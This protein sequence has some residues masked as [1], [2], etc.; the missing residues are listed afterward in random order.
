MLDDINGRF[1][2]LWRLYNIFRLLTNRII[3]LYAYNFD[4]SS[5]GY[6]LED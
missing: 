6:F 4:V 5:R 3:I 2:G 1:D